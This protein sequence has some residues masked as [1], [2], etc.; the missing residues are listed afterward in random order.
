MVGDTF[1][2]YSVPVLWDKKSS[3]IVNNE[4]SEILRM[5]NGPFARLV[6]TDKSTVDLYP[7][8][9]VEEIEAVNSWVYPTINN[10][11]YRCGFAKTQAAYDIAVGELSDSLDR[12]EELLGHQRYVSSNQQITEADVRLYMTLIRFDEVYVVYF[13]CNTRPISQY[14]NI[15]NYMRELYQLPWLQSTTNMD[16]IKRHYFTSH[17]VLNAYA[18]IPRGPRVLEDLLLEHDRD[19]FKTK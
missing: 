7:G 8:S 19:R 14:A 1:G 6:G 10:G 5:F 9:L 16:H 15:R 17:P 3:T 2:K 11:V 4:S 12:L 18:V 13:K